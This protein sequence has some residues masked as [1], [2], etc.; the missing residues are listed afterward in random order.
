MV[1]V[2]DILDI[3]RSLRLKDPHYFRS[4]ICLHIQ[5][6]QGKG[7]PSLVCPL[8]RAKSRV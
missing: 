3:D 7:G 5:V 6:D 4:W 1:M 8:D 2:I